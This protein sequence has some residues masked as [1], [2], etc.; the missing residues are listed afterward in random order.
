MSVDAIR[1]SVPYIY[2][3]TNINTDIYS[4]SFCNHEASFGIPRKGRISC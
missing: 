3:D 2:S 4:T 1:Q